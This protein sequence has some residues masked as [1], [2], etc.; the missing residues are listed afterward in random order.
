MRKYILYLV[1][2][3]LFASLTA[4]NSQ[5][6]NSPH[7]KEKKGE[8]VAYSSFS[9]RPKTLDPA[10]SYASNEVMF[11]GQIYESP[12]QYHYLR[13]PYTLIANLATKVPSPI[14]YDKQFNV[15]SDENSSKKIAYS[16]YDIEIKPG[17][18]YQPHPAFAK[19]AGKFHYHNLS[20][21]DINKKYTLSDFSQNGTRELKA[22]DFVYQIKRLAHPELNSPIL[23]LMS[24]YILGLDDYAASLKVKALNKNHFLDL[25]QFPLEGVSV[26]G[27]YRYKITLKGK[28]PQFSYWLAMPFFSPMPWEVE[29]FYSQPGFKKKNITLDWYPVGTGPYMLVENNP[30]RRMILE[31]N[32]NYR[33]EFYPSEGEKEDFLSGALERAGQPLPFVD[34][35]IFSLEKESIPRWNKFLQGYYDFSMVSGDS[36]DQAIRVGEQ[37]EIDLTE[38]MKEKNIHLHSS[39][40]PILY[41]MGFNM[42]DDVVGG[43]SEKAR[44]LRQAISIAVDFDEYITIF[45]N[46]HGVAAQGPIPPGIF[47]YQKGK[48][49]IN[50]YNYH[51]K[52]AHPQRIPIDYAKKLLAEAGYPNG[53]DPKTNKPLVLNYD[54]AITAGPDEKAQLV[55]IRQQ[56]KKLG[57]DLNIR[58]T[59]YNRFQDKVRRGD[60]EIFFFGW[61]ADYP[62]PENFLFL[63]YGPNSRVLHGGENTSNYRNEAY[64]ALFDKMKSIPNSKERQAIIDEMIEILR[65][66]APFI[67]GFHPKNFML[68]HDWNGIGKPNSIAN[69]LLK[70]RY[71]DSE[72]RTEKQLDWN[73]PIFWPL[74]LLIFLFILVL[75]PLAFFY[76][77]SEN[78]KGKAER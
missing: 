21:E 12:L 78:K 72:L 30:N 16:V 14:Y 58:A 25:R 35:F 46:G 62:D 6:K 36:F 29:A 24:E 27:P 38:E 17:V 75:L 42:L 54:V 5:A 32:P 8:V 7:A 59:Q 22:E 63:F 40:E 18:Y 9:E 2:C 11:T 20:Q 76:W 1:L 33:Q 71:L 19:E 3:F 50:P 34:K 64:D 60:V 56:F 55:W 41:Y 15:I 13:R 57:I 51:W 49:G 45:R 47:G 61:G 67:W 48:E 4:C 68:Q 65:H 52:N 43:R 23:G 77:R 26:L 28:Y 73:K 66:D 53:H 31:K 69:N 74:Y 37:G 70:Y 39:T 10:R 44:K